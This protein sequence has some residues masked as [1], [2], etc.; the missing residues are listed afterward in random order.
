LPACTTASGCL[1]IVNQS[2]ATSPLPS[3]PPSN[4]D[5]TVETALDLDMASAACPNCKLLLVQ[6][7]DDQGD[8]LYTAQG[9]AVS[10]G[11]TV[12]SNSWGGPEQAGSP[13][14]ATESYFN[15]PGVGIFV[16]AATPGTTMAVKARTIP[17]RRRT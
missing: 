8:G 9:T 17:V 15:H 6:A 12:V 13:A 5:W 3:A 10:L 2:G 4:D 7:D 14:T 16:A 11:A 1:T